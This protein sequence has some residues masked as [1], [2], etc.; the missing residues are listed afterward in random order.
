VCPI[1]ALTFLGIFEHPIHCMNKKY[2]LGLL[3]LTH[4]LI[5]ADGVV[6]TEET[7]AIK[8]IKLREGISDSAFEE[9][10]AFIKDKKEREIYQHGIDFINHCS[11][12]EKLKVFVMLYKLSEVDGRV[13]VSEIRLLLYSIKLAGVEFNDVVNLAMASPSLI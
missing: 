12:E 5:C 10:Q 8:I 6:V 9:F 13:H 7:D 11:D 2:Q 1:G 4:L 3:C